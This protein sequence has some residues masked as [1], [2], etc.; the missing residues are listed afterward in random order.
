MATQTASDF[1][2]PS[3]SLVVL[4]Q[5]AK[6]CQGCPLFL[7]ATQTV[8]GEGP[9]RSRFVIIGEVPGDE[10]DK[11][12]HPFVGSAGRLLDE[13]LIEA[14]IPRSEVY[15]TNVVKHFKWQ[16]KGK[17]RLH[18]KPN[19]REI[20]ACRPWLDREL[21]IIDPLVI[22]CLGATAAQSLL[23]NHFQV[24]KQRGKW[25]SNEHYEQIMAT[26]HPSA[27][28]R[29]PNRSSRQTMRKLLLLDLKKAYSI[30]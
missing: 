16:S 15:L 29:N 23:G 5:A 12:G 25:Q 24:T 6:H 8:F 19:A 11:R 21:E 3:D 4:R 13:L 2:P 17:R 30:L 10:E 27:I 18:A 28:L 26:Y 9:K 20:K 1:I 22:V 7:R 14:D